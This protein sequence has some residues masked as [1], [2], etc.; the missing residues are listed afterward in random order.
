M[1]KIL[2]LLSLAL[3]LAVNAVDAFAGDVEKALFHDLLECGRIVKLIAVNTNSGRPTADDIVRLRKSAEDIHAD[4]LLLGERYVALAGRTATLNNN[5]ADRQDTASTTLLDNLDDLLARLDAIGTT[6]TPSDLDSLKEI[7]DKLVPHKSSP[8]LGSLPYRHTNYPPREPAAI[9]VVKPAYKG[10]DRNVYAADTATTPEAPISKEIVDLAQLLQWNPVLIYE[11]V[12]NNVETEWYWGSMKGAEETLRQKSGNDADQATLL[13]ALLRAANFPAR[14][15]KGTIDFFPDIER[16]KN[17]TGLDDPAKIYTFLQ[18]AGIPVKP[19]IT[20]GGIANFQI[21]HIWVEAFIPYSNY[22]GAVVDDQGK[23]WLGLDTSIKPQGYTR[24][25]GA[26]VPADILAPLRDDYLNAV[27]TLSPLDYLKGKLN[28]SLATTQPPKTWSNL[29]DSAVMIP[30]VLKIIPSSL[31]FNQIAISG[32]YQTLPDELKHKVAFIATAGGN[33]LFSITLDALKLSNRKVA[34]RAEPETVEDQNTID[35]FG[36]QDNTPPY[37]VRL[38]PVLTVDGERMIV[39]QDGLPMGGDYT[40]NI[41][42]ITPNGTERISSSQINGNLSV[43]GVVAQKAQTPAAISEGDNAEAI[44]HKEAIGYIDRWN[45]A[46]D[47]LAALLGQSISRPTVSI[48][49][50]GAQLE[51]TQLLDIPHDM[52]WKGLSLDAGYRRIETVGRN[53][54]ERDFLRM[55]ALQGSILENHIFE[56][57]LKVDSVSTAKLLQ[58]AVTGGT[59]TVLIDKTNIDTIL[60]QLPFDDAVTGDITNAVNQGLTV[61][62]PQTEVA[63]QNWTG[64]GYI[65]EDPQTGESGWMLSG[66]VAGGMTAWSGERW[67]DPATRMVAEALMAPYSSPPSTDPA[68]ATLIAKIG[69]TDQQSDVAGKQLAMPLKVMVFDAAGRPVQGVSVHFSVRAGGGTFDASGAIMSDVLTNSKG[70]AATPFILG[71]K[72]GD[73]PTAYTVSTNQYSVQ[74]GENLVSAVLP[75]GKGIVAPFSLYGLPGAPHHITNNTAPRTDMI[76]NYAGPAIT[77]VAD[78]N[79][80]PVANS[81]VQFQAADAVGFAACYT[82]T[83]AN[84]TALVKTDNT[85]FSKVPHYGECGAPVT[86]LSVVTDYFGSAAVGVMLGSIPGA[87]YNVVATATAIQPGDTRVPSVTLSYNTYPFGNQCGAQGILDPAV[88]FYTTYTF[89]VDTFGNNINAARSGSNVPLMGRTYALKENA[90]TANVT[91]SCG[92]SCNKIVGA[93]TFT[94]TT[95]FITSG[96]IFSSVDNSGATI[97]QNGQPQGNGIFTLSYTLKPGVNTIALKGSATMARDRTVLCPTCSTIHENIPL[98]ST[99]TM[100]I[101]GIDIIMP[102]V[103][104]LVVTTDNN[105]YSLNDLIVQYTINPPEYKA[106]I[107]DVV[108]YRNGEPIGYTS[109]VKS[110]TGTAAFLKGYLF[111]H[112][113]SYDVQLILNNGSG[114]EVKSDKV[115]ISIV[116][117]Q[118]NVQRT[119]H[120]SQFDA[121]VPTNI[122]S[123]YTDSFTP[124]VPVKVS[125]PAIVKVSLLDANQL[126][127]AVLVPNTSLPA[128]DYSFVVDFDQI[129]NAGFSPTLNP[130]Y[131]IKVT[132]TYGNPAVAHVALYSGQMSERTEGKMLGQTMVHDVLIQDGSLNLTRQDF[133]FAGRGQQL[134]FTRSY[135]NQSSP[136]DIMPLGNGWSH[137]LDLKLRPLSSQT[138]GIGGLPTW[139]IPLKGQIFSNSVIPTTSPGLTMVQV[140]GATF[141]KYNGVWYSERGRHG[142]LEEITATPITPAGFAFTAKDGTRY[143]YN[144]ALGDMPVTRI[145]DRNG[146][147]M[148]FTYDGQLLTNIT[149]TVGRKCDFSYDTL[150]GPVTGDRTRMTGMTCSDA[151]ELLFSYHPNGYL[152]SVTRGTRVE[153]YDYAQENG[154][155]GGEYNLVK[156]TDANNNSFS[157]EYH[158]TTS[159]P[160]ISWNT[161]KTVKPLKAQDVVKSVTY[162]GSG[163]TPVQANFTYDV[164]TSNKRTVT[165][166]RGNDTVYTLNYFGNPLKIEEPLGK[167]T[168]MTWSI[169]E[170]KPDNVMTSKTDPQLNSTSYE[171][172]PQGNIRKETDSYGKIITTTWNQKF[173]MPEGRTDR[174]GTVRS[175]QYDAKGNLLSETDGDRKTTSHTYYATGER[176][177][178]RDPLGNTTTFTYDN[179]GN[180]ATVLG[181]ENSLTKFENDVRGRRTALIDPNGKRTEYAYDD[182]DY[183]TTTTFP[184]HGS[185]ALAD[186]S[187][188]I[189]TQVHDAVGNLVSETDRLGLTLTYTYTPRNQV[190]TITRSSGGTKTF[191]YDNNG[192]LTSESDW[193]GNANTSPHVYDALNRRVRTYNRLG[194]YTSFAYDLNGNLTEETDAEGRVTNHEYD[195]LNRLTKTIQPALP[196]LARG[197]LSYTYYDEADPKTNLKTET[198]QEGNSTSYE[199]NGRYLRSKRTNA[200]LDN[201]I[202][203]YDDAGNLSKETDEEN[204]STRH[205]YDR[206]NRLTADIRSHNGSDIKTGYG[207]DAAGNR[208]SVTDPLGHTTTMKYD[209]WNRPWQVIDAENFTVTSELDGEGNKVKTTDANG[210]TRTMTRDQRGLVLSSIDGEG[211]ETKFTYDLN[212]NPA[213]VT[214]ANGSNTAIA[215]DAEDRK[216]LTTEAQGKPEERTSGVVLYDKVGNPLQTKDGNGNVTISEYNALNLPVKITDARGNSSSSDYYRTGKVKSVTNRRQAT[217]TT[218]YDK[219]WRVIKVTDPLNQTI[220]STYDKVGNALTAKD[221]RGIVSETLYDDLYRPIEKRRDNLRLA[222]LEYDSAGNLTADIDA[223]GNRTEYTYTKRNQKKQTTYADNTNRSFTYDGNGNLASET[224]EEGIDTNYG[225]DRENRLTA[226]ERAGETT[227][228]NYD[229][230]GNLSAE[231]RPEGNSRT[232]G[233]DLLRRMT[234]VTDDP[235]GPALTTRYEYDKNNNRTKTID[236]RLNVVENTYDELNLKKSHTQKKATGDLVTNY[237]YDEEGNLTSLTDAK[238]QQS[239]Y[240]Y[241]ELNRRKESHYSGLDITTSYD[242]NNNL[243]DNYVSGSSTDSNVNIYDTFDRLL[244]STQRGTQVNYSYDNNGN[245]LSVGTDPVLSTSTFNSTTNYTYDTRNRVKTASATSTPLSTGAG[246]ATTNFD[247]YADGKKKTVSYPNG[248]K[249]EYEYYPT[250]RVK[251]L[252][253]SLNSAVISKF[254]YSYDR[255]GNRLT[256]DEQRGSRN[257]STGYTYDSLD[258][259]NSYSVTENSATTRT[260]YT[261]EGYNRKTEAT[262]ASTPLST[263]PDSTNITKTYN[264]DDTDWLTQINDGTKTIDYIYDNNGNTQQKTDSTDATNPIIFEYD[265]RD[266]LTRTTKGATIL[267][268]YAYNANGYRIRQ[269]NSDRGNVDYLYDGTAVIEERNAGGLLAH[270]RYAGKL[271]SLFDGT[272]SQYYHQ[273]ALGSTV[274]LTDDAGT[275]K[276][277]YFLNPW[278]MIVDS[279][280]QSVNRRVFTGKEI[281]QN[282]GLIYF[283]ARYYDPD[284]AR[285]TTPDTYLG[286]QATPPSLHRYLYAYSN[287]TVFI[288]LEGYESNREMWGLDEKSVE[289][290]AANDNS[291]WAATK[292]AAKATGYKVWNGVTGGFL[293]RQDTRQEK[294]DRGQISAS[295]YWK[296]TGIDATASI[297]TQVVAGGLLGKA[298]SAGGFVKTMATGAAVSGGSS[299]VEQTAQVAT[300][301]AT[302]GRLG[303]ESIDVGQV[304]ESAA[305]GA[306]VSGGLY[307]AGKIVRQ[308]RSAIASGKAGGEAAL[309]GEDV[310]ASLPTSG[311]PIDSGVGNYANANGVTDN[312]VQDTYNRLSRRTD[313]PGQAH[314][315]NQTAAYRDIIPTSQGISI[316]LEGNILTDAGAPHTT[317]HKSLEQFWNEYR[318]TDI[319]P[320]NIEYTRALQESLRA[321]GLSEQHVQQAIK[322]AIR[323]RIKAGALGGMEV[324]RVPRPIRNLAE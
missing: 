189:K 308:V 98:D 292:Y 95:D 155:P 228:K 289:K 307:G 246:T 154:I 291:W 54:N 192:N 109:G 99:S 36:G 142:T 68:S 298:A 12:K 21:E 163:T 62:I 103:S 86:N 186:G 57:D 26:G 131:Y 198:D 191:D 219:L 160:L 301:H 24:T 106:Q 6:T 235:W 94:E 223:N 115:P 157:Y 247:Y 117:G 159:L 27:Q 200:L 123:P 122:G 141:K 139:L 234:S 276:A 310:T 69:A 105:G 257:I 204:H 273:D 153:T 238:G 148:S 268:S 74:V 85:C 280:G 320:T 283:G 309:T 15:I 259:M 51:V 52:Q 262:T 177:T 260:D 32:E 287:P 84:P 79:D 303:Q 240:V 261:F 245:R 114:V 134:A 290:A 41:D 179:W 120:L 239:S 194:F 164:T 174:N 230:M 55:S 166:L 58:L 255:N 207:Y 75:N 237:G 113:Y 35:S 82:L 76:L 201:H 56:D 253:N 70:V 11:W 302:D 176:Q 266:K 121:T 158:T 225:Y 50:V 39:A 209:E 13:V 71:K 88:N 294:L 285:F 206:Q 182:L 23:I 136:H 321:S 170:S 59:P 272:S 14:Y 118:L 77:T 199:Y 231:I 269:N 126:E 10:G 3:L 216:G 31:Q 1:K 140:N 193:K 146:N 124:L 152:K 49:T 226:S 236:A 125:E 78:E 90:T 30:E 254:D 264:Y 172:D 168:L 165:D 45:K 110:G 34:L 299:L 65:K 278:G 286:E 102:K 19:V 91:G 5:A 44:L 20:G 258:R 93:R 184:Q 16:A 135:T 181:A 221:K 133:A 138:S 187:G 169:D 277:S 175:W 241:D 47:D 167:T 222:T 162:P 202:W 53:G 145:E 29:K 111:E 210:T 318:G 251:T 233:Y 288:D 100:T 128:G 265:A 212:N 96:L 129:K 183:P 112:G 284:T 196:G 304:V 256:Q 218:E 73:N 116:G 46:E 314:H 282:T 197:E 267:G 274:D 275:T 315:L 42:I 28:D 195:K 17:L 296:G 322:A 72:T 180:L 203:E 281:D 66:N 119:H 92:V 61:T 323:E 130:N 188:R 143:I 306:L 48:A 213:T 87:Q 8:L 313:I 232:F 64:I 37:L 244:R 144:N 127:N 161:T 97:D 178:S 215:Y 89:L 7:I 18:K 300:Y 147:A 38:R 190:K 208:T 108:L 243:I 227:Q 319:V 67:D 211:A 81:P 217:T 312:L 104:D 305:S 107:A 25:Q 132:S 171:Y 242:G 295:D 151:V 83:D 317:A 173:S 252:T 248:A 220:E 279:I 137:S 101:F 205:E 293:E 214:Y 263:G 63:Y 316:K 224:D 270:Y 40:L 229:N 22:R 185:Y 311:K 271:Y 249:E 60:P 149:D 9:P 156:A 324:P 250:N 33:E 80:N 297:S 43:I 4:R 2:V 150:S